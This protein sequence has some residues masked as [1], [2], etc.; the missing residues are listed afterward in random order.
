MNTSQ[1]LRVLQAAALRMAA[2]ATTGALIVACT[3]GTGSGGASPPGP[4]APT[5]APTSALTSAP[6][7]APSPS[8]EATPR[9]TIAHATGVGDL[10][11]RAS[12]GGGLLPIDMRL[13][14]IPD[15]SIYGDGTVV[16]VR[17][18]G[19]GPTDPLGPT[20]ARAKLTPEGMQRVL[21]A[22]DQA[23]LRG[24]D[25]RYDLEDVYDLWVTSFQLKVDGATHRI[26]AYALGFNE[27]GRLAP[28]EDVEP[29]A[30]LLEFFQRLTDLRG[31]LGADAVTTDEL[32]VAVE[33]RV[34]VGP[35]DGW[36]IEATPGPDNRPWPL[37][38]LPEQF[39]TSL[40]E[41]WDGWRCAVLDG[42]GLKSLGVDTFTNGTRWQVMDK[43]YEARL[44]PLLP[45]ESGCPSGT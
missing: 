35:D 17:A 13:T 28:P 36:R 40:G 20:I 30:R 6:T 8:V 39:G 43:S 11:L 34:F 4:T 9:G 41:H 33:T 29:R 12:Q 24:P 18:F 5:S 15:V 25:R 19:H 45:D 27:E 38:I 31:W 1:G 10:V 44:R 37:D 7:Q 14:E 3:S 26:S 42:A 21:A 23:G 2:I 16:T 22:A 32:Y